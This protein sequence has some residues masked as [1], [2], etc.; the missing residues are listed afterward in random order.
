MEST[1]QDD[2]DGPTTQRRPRIAFEEDWDVRYWKEF[3]VRT[4]RVRNEG[5]DTGRTP[6]ERISAARYQ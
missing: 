5:E 6:A 2:F 4:D 3:R 1:M